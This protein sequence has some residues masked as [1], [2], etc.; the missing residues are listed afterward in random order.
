M[1]RH[2]NQGLVATSGAIH[3]SHVNFTWIHGPT[4]VPKPP[5]EHVYTGD[6][7]KGPHDSHPEEAHLKGA[8]LGWVDP[9]IGRTDNGSADPGPPHG[10][11]PLVLEAIPG[12][13]HSS[14]RW[15][16]DL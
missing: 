15:C 7:P 2:L 5:Q 16:L 6:R 14:W 12:V 13:F 8:H 4:K 11:C 1:P 10:A 9:W 3:A